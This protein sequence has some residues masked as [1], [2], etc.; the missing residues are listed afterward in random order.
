[1]FRDHGDGLRKLSRRQ[2]RT[3]RAITSCRTAALGGHVKS[4]D[5]CEHREIAYNSCRNRH[6]PKCQS[7]EQVRWVEAQQAKLLP[8]EYHHVVFTLPDMLH[9]LL[10]SNTR[11][12]YRLLFAAVAGTLDEVARRPKN[13]G[14]RIGVTAV[15]H[16]W[17]QT[18]GFHPHI[19]CIVTGGGMSC[20]G[21]RWVPAKP[22]FLFHVSVLS[23]V[24]RGIMLN[25]LEE[26]VESGE[27]GASHSDG[28]DRLRHAARKDWN[29]YSKAPFAGPDQVLRYL[30]RYTHRAAIS[31]DRLV[32]MDD[33]RVAFR[34][35][36]RANDN[37]KKV[38][39]LEATEF[40]RR[41]LMHVLPSGFHRIRHYGLLANANSATCIARCRAL[42]GVEVPLEEKEAARRES[43]QDLLLRVTG[44]D[45][46]QCP[47]CR[48]GRLTIVSRSAPA[49]R[50]TWTSTRA[51][52]TT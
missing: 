21:A 36:D 26:A 40:L 11:V 25:K 18:L 32:S 52:P 42:L 28:R 27:L 8:I 34:W 22:R 50:R 44:K 38:M 33:G 20:C 48:A 30:G 24:F 14:A 7:L 45:P 23:L 4:C 3:A 19:H 51:P 46:M 10:L 2:A 17:N 15:L 1:M 43:W 29:V 49:S 47:K 35:R 6:C 37:R 39:T 13:L 9:R 41:F 16:T 12:G 5:R 31:N